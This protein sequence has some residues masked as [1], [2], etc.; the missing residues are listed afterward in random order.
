MSVSIGRIAQ[1]ELGCL[2]LAGAISGLSGCGDAPAGSKE[3]QR[4]SASGKVT[5]DGQPI[6]AGGVGFQHSESGNSV[7]CLITNGT[8]ESA[9]GEGPFLGKNTVTV[10]GSDGPNGTPL[11]S[12]AWSREVEITGDTFAQ[13][14]DVKKSDTKPYKPPKAGPVDPGAAGDE[15]KPLNE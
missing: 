12:G 9:S 5:F 4:A 14:F 6:A 10:S 8:Y 7:S 2:I 13:D 15:E 11:W 1:M 3:R